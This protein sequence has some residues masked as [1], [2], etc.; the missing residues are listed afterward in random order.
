MT[1]RVRKQVDEL[2]ATDFEEYPCWE[3]ASDEEGRNGQDECTVRPLALPLTQAEGI[4]VFV[5]AV[6]FFPG[7][8]VRLGMVTLNA[9]DDPSG[10]QPV[11]FLG[12]EALYF[13]NGSS[14]PS[15]AEVR[16]FRRALEEISPMPFPVRYV[17]SLQTQEGRPLAYGELRGLYWLANWRTNELHTAA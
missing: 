12:K 8:R 14:E 11:V 2:R 7:G 4:Q 3:Y 9:G 1:R 17:S 6:F 15:K 13:Y 16:A 10:H 5:Q